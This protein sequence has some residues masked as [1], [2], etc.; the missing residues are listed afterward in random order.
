MKFVF[1]TSV[2]GLR[3]KE[4]AVVKQA[5]QKAG[6]ELEL[7]SV[8]GSVFFSSDVAN[9]D[10]YGKFYADMQMYT[11]TMTQPDPERFMDQYT[12]REISAKSNK[13]Q[14]RN[15]CRWNN[16][17]YDKTMAEAKVELDVV[18][19]TALFIK[20]NDLPCKDNIIIPLIS[21]PR[22]RGMAL[23]LEAPLTGFDL[24][25]SQLH[26]WYRKS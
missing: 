7:K 10:T 9:P 23:S 4:Q 21:R 24:D 11:T 1:Q 6:I 17:E 8:V 12:S 16:P 19:R 25:F 13:W 20:L 2:N 5:C 26:N 18:K 22:P 15:I 3:Q 14:G